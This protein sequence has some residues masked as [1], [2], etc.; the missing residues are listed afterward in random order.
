ML[1]GVSGAAW[2]ASFVRCHRRPGGNRESI[3]RMGWFKKHRRGVVAGAAIVAVLL[4]LA[5]WAAYRPT[6]FLEVVWSQT[7]AGWAQAVGT[8]AAVIFAWWQGQR[9][10]YLADKRKRDETLR[11]LGHVFGLTTKTLRAAQQS[12]TSQVGGNAERFA[13]LAMVLRDEQRAFAR[14]TQIPV[15]AWPSASLASA[16]DLAFEALIEVTSDDVTIISAMKKGRLSHDVQK[17]FGRRVGVFGARCQRLLDQIQFYRS[18]NEG[19]PGPIIHFRAE[20]KQ[21]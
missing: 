6:Q 10:A 19:G 3:E 9:G 7:A 8:V 14:V 12:L 5:G 2:I 16:V 13:A 20:P 21:G 1:E 18:I 17:D 4:M 11:F 15:Q